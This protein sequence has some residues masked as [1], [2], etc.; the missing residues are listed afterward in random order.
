MSLSEAEIFLVLCPKQ[1]CYCQSGTHYVSE[2]RSLLSVLRGKEYGK[3]IFLEG[4]KDTYTLTA[5]D[6]ESFRVAAPGLKKGLGKQPTFTP[7]KGKDRRVLNRETARKIC[8]ALLHD[9]SRT[10][11]VME[12][13]TLPYLCDAVLSE[14]GSKNALVL[15][16]SLGTGESRRL[17]LGTD[18]LQTLWKSTTAGNLFSVLRLNLGER[19]ID[20]SLLTE[21]ELR[22]MVASAELHTGH[23]FGEKS[24]RDVA[25]LL[26]YSYYAEDFARRNGLILRCETPRKALRERLEQERF[27]IRL[28]E[29]AARA[30]E[31]EAEGRL[32]EKLRREYPNATGRER[33]EENRITRF[34]DEVLRLSVPEEK[35]GE[36][37]ALR[38]FYATP[39]NR[40]LSKGAEE[41][42]MEALDFVREMYREGPTEDGDRLLK[43]LM[44][45]V[46]DKNYLHDIDSISEAVSLY[47]AVSHEA[48][49]AGKTEEIIR[50]ILEEK[51]RD[52]ALCEER[53]EETRTDDL[54]RQWNRCN[55]S[56]KVGKV[57]LQ[58][59]ND[60]KQEYC[61]ALERLESALH[62]YYFSHSTE[63]I[64]KQKLD[65]VTADMERISTRYV[66]LHTEELQKQL[67][68]A[69]VQSSAEETTRAYEAY[70]NAHPEKRAANI[71]KLKQWI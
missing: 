32:S 54:V 22:N 68:T 51:Q 29:D 66:E 45:H 63:G 48:A 36:L 60:E 70:F 30:L 27:L 20:R 40:P 28:R 62:Q 56:I 16:S 15:R 23:I 53:L 10:A 12:L 17:I 21:E 5:Y 43:V 47:A 2:D 4:N 35:Q 65:E 13:E 26:Y 7:E 8:N 38:D 33:R 41:N 67:E 18:A 52:F 1:E 39:W 49:R 71:R 64:S 44:D 58:R 14:S 55:E 3:V 37:K 61:D 25:A 69:H 50:K 34:I 59:A 19:F 31:G 9:G 6:E 57:S 11:L 46:T 24:R 42:L